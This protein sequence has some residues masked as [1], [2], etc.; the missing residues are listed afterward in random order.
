MHLD[1]KQPPLDDETGA[2]FVYVL[3]SGGGGPCSVERNPQTHLIKT[4]QPRVWMA[5]KGERA[6]KK[7]VLFSYGI[8]DLFVV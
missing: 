8:S 5:L 7:S 3:G 2:L 4:P 6:P 1:R